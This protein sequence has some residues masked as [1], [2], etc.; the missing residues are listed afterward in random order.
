MDPGHSPIPDNDLANKAAKEATTIA[1]DTILSISLSS[2]IQVINETIRDAPPI[3]KPV[4]S[5]YKHRRGSPDAKQINNR[6]DGVL[7]ARLQSAHHP[8]LNQYLHRLDPS[9]DPACPNCCQEEQDLLYWLCNCPALM[10]V[11]QL[12]C[13]Q[14]SLEW[15]ATRPGDV[16]VCARKTL[17]NLD[18]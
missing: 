11:R 4:A 8:S 16:V 2:S 17:V 18:P 6:K 14:G 7:I 1:T 10:T 15:L 13:H 5:V 3:L 9:Q 12:W